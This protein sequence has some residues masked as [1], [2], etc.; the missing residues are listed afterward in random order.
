VWNREAA[1]TWHPRAVGRGCP[2]G[3]P[4]VHTGP[5]THQPD[6]AGPDDE[7][8]RLRA[9]DTDPTVLHIEGEVDVAVVEAFADA[10]GV[11]RDEV[12]RA[13][14]AAGVATVDMARATF[15]DSSMIA[16]LAGIASSRLPE[17]VRVLGATGTPLLALEATGIDALF[18]ME[19]ASEAERAPR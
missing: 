14:G 5:V 1:G 15:I 16:V 11:R 10:S 18:T 9:D 19:S 12:G 2:R 17:R 6:S 4:R 7:A 13:L 3:P 8:G